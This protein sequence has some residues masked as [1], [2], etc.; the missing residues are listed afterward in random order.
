MST[1]KKVCSGLVSMMSAPHM[2]RWWF[3]PCSVSLP[4]LRLAPASAFAVA[5]RSSQVIELFR[6]GVEHCGAYWV[7]RA[8]DDV[9]LRLQ[10]TLELLMQHPP[11]NLYAGL[12][13]EGDSMVVPRPELFNAT[14]E[15][16][17]RDTKSWT[18]DLQDYPSHKLP[19]FAQGNAFILSRDL[20]EEGND[21]L[22][23]QLCYGLHVVC[24]PLTLCCAC[25]V[26]PS[27]LRRL[28]ASPG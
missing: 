13:I 6:W 21:S 24:A 3:L 22:R 12:L 16:I 23:K 28:H 15:S 8:N 4:H 26:V 2:H 11:V 5:L 19:S 18:F 27:Q 14:K 9:Y 25:V 7:A 10:P 17:Y 1:P 20:A